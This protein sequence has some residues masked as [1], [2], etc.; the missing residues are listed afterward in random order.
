MQGHGKDLIRSVDSL[1]SK[2]FGSCFVAP[3]L[4][5]KSLDSVFLKKALL[6]GKSLFIKMG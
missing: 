2:G 4:L 5:P 3:G 6:R 1:F